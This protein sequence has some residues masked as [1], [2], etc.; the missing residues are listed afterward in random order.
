M[1]YIYIYDVVNVYTILYICV[2]IC[3]ILHIYTYYTTY[4]QYNCI[5]YNH[6]YYGIW[7]YIYIC[8]ITYI[9]I[10]IYMISPLLIPMLLV[11]FLG[12]PQLFSHLMPGNIYRK[13]L[14]CIWKI[15][16]QPYMFPLNQFRYYICP[17]VCCGQNMV[18]G[19]MVSHRT[20]KLTKK[21]TPKKKVPLVFHLSP[22]VFPNQNINKYFKGSPIGAWLHHG[23]A[24]E[25]IE[26]TEI[27]TW[28]NHHCS[29]GAT[30]CHTCGIPAGWAGW[31][32]S[33]KWCCFEIKKQW[34]RLI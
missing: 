15:G 5:I 28:L 6:V 1:L 11:M 14:F 12:Y 25:A 30:G 26:G 33:W 10:Y 7:Y 3:M 2:C 24:V 18:Y 29:A 4:I 16:I 32:F 8:D 21:L 34:T 17:D 13:P 23:A 22:E 31:L 19:G 27:A 20:C 9:H